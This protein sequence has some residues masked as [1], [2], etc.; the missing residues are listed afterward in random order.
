[1]NGL[2]VEDPQKPTVSNLQVHRNVTGS[3]RSHESD[4]PEDPTVGSCPEPHGGPGGGA[5]VSNERRTPVLCPL[6]GSSK[7]DYHRRVPRRRTR[8]FFQG[9]P[10]QSYRIPNPQPSTLNPQPWDL[11]FEVSC[12]SC[13][14]QE[15]QTPQP[16]LLLLRY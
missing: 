1:M 9:N 12:A 7:A 8:L 16:E 13:F 15:P 11:T 10:P 4:P 2:L 6:T 14:E 3:P 5:A